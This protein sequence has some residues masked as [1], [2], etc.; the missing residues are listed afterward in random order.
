MPVLRAG[1][2]RPGRGSEPAENRGERDLAFLVRCP[3]R[4]RGSEPAENRGEQLYAAGPVLAKAVR[5]RAR[6]EPR[7][8]TEQWA[9]RLP[10]LPPRRREPAENQENYLLHLSTDIKAEPRQ[11]PAENRAAENP[12]HLVSSTM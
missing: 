2:P 9:T 5:S 1:L 3:A 7:R 8:T 12:N 11:W 6:G 4:G 10:S